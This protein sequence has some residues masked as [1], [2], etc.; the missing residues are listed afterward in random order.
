MNEI[1]RGF[2]SWLSEEAR[3]KLSKTAP[4][5]AG[6]RRIMTIIYRLFDSQYRVHDV[7]ATLNQRQ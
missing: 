5:I 3:K 7:V 1:Q 6:I 2:V 4:K